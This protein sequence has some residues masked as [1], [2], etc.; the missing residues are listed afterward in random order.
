LIVDGEVVAAALLGIEARMQEWGWNCEDDLV[1]ALLVLHAGRGTSGRYPL[2][3]TV[4]PVSFAGGEPGD[5]LIRFAINLAFS[6]SPV[7]ELILQ[8]FTEG[9]FAGFAFAH[10]AWIWRRP[11]FP[12]D[13]VSLADQPGSEEARGIMAVDTSDVAWNVLR[14]RG[15]QPEVESFPVGSEGGSPGGRIVDALRILTAATCSKLPASEHRMPSL[16]VVLDGEQVTVEELMR[17]MYGELP[18]DLL[19]D[20]MRARIGLGPLG[21]AS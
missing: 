14:V 4:V 10:E 8:G 7:A 6:P 12:I 2:E 3:C 19:P 15:E 21:N 20:R 1:P 13:G 11:E 5:L 9:G 17:R 16:P 18:T